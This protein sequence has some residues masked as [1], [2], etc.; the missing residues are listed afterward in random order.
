MSVPYIELFTK[1]NTIPSDSKLLSSLNNQELTQL[2]TLFLSKSKS[3]YFKKCKTD[4]SDVE[5]SDYYN[6]TF[7]GD[8]IIDTFTID[9]YPMNPNPNAIDYICKVNGINV[10]YTFD[11]A[12]LTFELSIVPD[13]GDNVVCGYEF[14]GQFNNDVTD[15]EQW[16]LVTFMAIVW[17]DSK[18][19]KEEKTRN[20]MT[21]KDY[22][23]S[24]EGNLLD[25]LT[26]LRKEFKKE[27]DQ[28]VY[29]YSFNGF[30]GF[31]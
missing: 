25:K 14:C 1:Y 23:Q 30:S 11:E 19:M 2:L 5:N 9:K 13:L 16:I 10:D 4:L 8:G 24:S 3:V 6:Q 27:A 28:M 12:T 18:I 29:D 31:N 15:E 21:S 17:L 22:R 20:K 26:L 7:I